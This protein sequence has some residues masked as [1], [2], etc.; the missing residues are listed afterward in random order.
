MKILI[1]AL[2]SFVY[3]SSLLV[4]P[5]LEVFLS[6]VLLQSGIGRSL[7]VAFTKPVIDLKQCAKAAGYEGYAEVGVEIDEFI[8]NLNTYFNKVY[9]FLS[10]EV[11]AR[12][13]KRKP[14][15]RKFK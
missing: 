7:S 14:I 1:F 4:S 3:V 13:F 15:N 11:G 2:F 8:V 5:F 12:D 10:P 9:G 6:G